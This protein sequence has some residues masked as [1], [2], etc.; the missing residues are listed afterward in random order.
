[1]VLG[2]AVFG[3]EDAVADP[4]ACSLPAEM[5]RCAADSDWWEVSC[6]DDAL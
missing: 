2:G 3:V 4:F 1:M 5:T 6:D